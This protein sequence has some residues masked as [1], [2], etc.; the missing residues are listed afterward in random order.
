MCM[1]FLSSAV[2]WCADTGSSEHVGISGNLGLQVS[3]P[4]ALYPM[5]ACPCCHLS[6]INPHSCTNLLAEMTRQGIHIYTILPSGLQKGFPMYVVR[7][8][9]IT[10]LL[11]F[12]PE[13]LKNF[14]NLLSPHD[15]TSTQS[16]LS[17][18]VP[19]CLT[20]CT[21]WLIICSAWVA[22]LPCVQA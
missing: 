4:A 17:A 1:S 8:H 13:L 20:T 21:P 10:Q 6:F 7:L 14:N 11:L 3:C 19:S 22:V 12:L 5:V 15:L 16:C 9:G 18:C 2:A